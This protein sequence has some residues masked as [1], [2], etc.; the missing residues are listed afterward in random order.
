MQK[1]VERVLVFCFALAL[2]YILYDAFFLPTYHQSLLKEKGVAA[3]AIRTGVS[4]GSE[5]GCS[6]VY[7]FSINN[8]DFRGF[9]DLDLFP[10]IKD[11]DT[12]SMVYLSTAPVINGIPLELNTASVNWM[13]KW[14][15]WMNRTI[16]VVFSDGEGNGLI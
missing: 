4:C 16:L 5:G 13:S 3:L 10:N 12:L 9:Y 8:R 7:T 15:H 1:F 6:G 14:R 2:C 11:G